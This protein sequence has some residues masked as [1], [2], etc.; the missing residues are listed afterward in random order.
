MQV[1]EEVV[2]VTMGPKASAETL[3]QALALGADR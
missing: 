3:R 2:A 1:A